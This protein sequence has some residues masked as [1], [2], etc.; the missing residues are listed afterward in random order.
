[1]QLLTHQHLL[2]HNIKGKIMTNVF[3][4]ID[5][6]A[7]A[8][9]QPASPEN[10]EMYIGLIDEEYTEL[11][12]A[13]GN[14]DDVEQLDALIDILVVTMGAIRAAGFNGEGAWK[15][16]M[17]TNFAKIDEKTG[18]VNKREDGKVLKPEGW[19]APDLTAFV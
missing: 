1:M 5:T 9:D 18:K 7:T 3:K 6:F 17:K 14:N 15:E 13:L 10:Y 19:V 8:C 16:V 2:T 11:Q 12:T 4:D